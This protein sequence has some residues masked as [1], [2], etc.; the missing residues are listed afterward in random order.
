AQEAHEAIRPAG[1]RFRTPEQLRGELHGNEAA[2]YDLIW[3]RT[4]ASQMADARGETVSVRIGAAASDG[5]DAE[6]GT[7]GT[8]ITVRGLMKAYEEGRDEAVAADEEERQ[9]PPLAEGDELG[10][11]ALEPESHTTTP[12]SRYTEATL[13]RALEERGIGRPSTY[14][15]ILGTIIEREY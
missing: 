3:K 2:L 15:S 10:A 9:L 5:T 4:I 12:P 8:G 1:D 14:A 7:A 11:T 13:V 6:F